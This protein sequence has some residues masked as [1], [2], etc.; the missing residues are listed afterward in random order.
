MNQHGYRSRH[1]TALILALALAAIAG[2][3][4]YGFAL[5]MRQAGTAAKGMVVGSLAES[6][7]RMGARHAYEVVLSDFAQD[8]TGV[9]SPVGR[10]LTEFADHDY[11][12]P[13]WNNVNPQDHDP[14]AE[15]FD[16]DG[17]DLPSES[18][19]YYP[20]H[21]E[22]NDGSNTYT[23]WGGGWPASDNRTAMLST[24]MARY[25]E[26]GY[27]NK[28]GTTKPVRFSKVPSSAPDFNKPLWLDEDFRP[29]TSRSRARYRL[30]YAVSAMDLGGHLIYGSQ[31]AYDKTWPLDGLTLT[32]DASKASPI[33]WNMRLASD[34]SRSFFNMLSGQGIND[35]NRYVPDKV[36]RPALMSMFLG[37]GSS[38]V[39]NKL[40]P[41]YTLVGFTPGGGAVLPYA[42]IPGM[43]IQKPVPM[44]AEFGCGGA[45]GPMS[46][47]SAHDRVDTVGFDGDWATRWV[48]SPFGRATKYDPSAGSVYFES[49]RT[50]CPWRINAVTAPATT[51]RTMLLAYLPPEVTKSTAEKTVTTPFIEWEEKSWPNAKA[52]KWADQGVEVVHIPKV[53][54]SPPGPGIDLL[55]EDFAP[56]S[57]KTA[58]SSFKPFVGFKGIDYTQPVDYMNPAD[59]KPWES[60][61]PG[62]SGIFTPAPASD[63]AGDA[64]A[65][66]SKIEDLYWESY[67]AFPG[68]ISR[69]FDDYK[70]ALAKGNYNKDNEGAGQWSP[71]F[72]VAN[73]N[74]TY[75]QFRASVRKGML[76]GDIDIFGLDTHTEAGPN[77]LGVL[78]GREISGG[79]AYPRDVMRGLGGPAG[80]IFPGDGGTEAIWEDPPGTWKGERVDYIVEK[81]SFFHRDSYWWDI[82]A[83]TA[84]ALVLAK[85]LYLEDDPCGATKTQFECA[86]PPAKPKH[87]RDLDRLFLAILGEYFPDPTDS[88]KPK[89]GSPGKQAGHIVLRREWPTRHSVVDNTVSN[90]IRSV[91]D[92]LLADEQVYNSAT[93]LHPV[94]YPADVKPYPHERAANME[95]VLNDWRMSFFGANPTYSD[96]RP[97]DFDGDG[98]VVASC[99]TNK[100]TVGKIQLP[101]SGADQFGQGLAPE[102][103]WSL[104]GY[105]VFERGRFWRVLSRGEVYD[106]RL[107][108]V[109]AESNLESVYAID[110]DGNFNS[111]AVNASALNDSCTLYQRWMD[112]YYRGFQA[113]SH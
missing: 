40:L 32:A 12:N 102:H 59:F 100:V 92:L 74:P 4:A 110:P 47:A 101:G 7:A 2:I 1:G 104:T 45:G 53:P 91:K 50:D 5:S 46:W 90:N 113:M 24:G 98:K 93:T 29:V 58:T 11:F 28:D 6:A 99:Y 60:S 31:A 70:A 68:N 97:L 25:I 39:L 88:S 81:P 18:K 3:V 66:P 85:A 57:L 71:A 69:E 15:V 27:Y 36:S 61:Y 9:T 21:D 64:P 17:D 51:I 79:R 86:V 106:E 111:I 84:G 52:A 112:N 42:D 19:L 67:A 8:P 20:H 76:G 73:D 83:A 23:N 95:R 96:F 16:T 56:Q 78:S 80:F 13:A 30:R 14:A 54:G 63:P 55:T 103:Y 38:S 48:Y 44:A 35:Y 22:S 77:G 34:Y 26:P 37:H 75:D 82:E 41:Q 62:S 94:K 10:H 108:K 87:V 109:V 89:P 107:R 65:Q 105:F 33:E 43:V 49:N 72:F